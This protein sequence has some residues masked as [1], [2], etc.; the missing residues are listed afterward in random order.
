MAVDEDV[1]PNVVGVIKA[2]CT[3]DRIGG[4]KRFLSDLLDAER[5]RTGGTGFTAL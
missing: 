4:E 1:V 5:I 2:T 3:T